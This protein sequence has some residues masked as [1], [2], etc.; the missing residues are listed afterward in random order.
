MVNYLLILCRSMEHYPLSGKLYRGA[1]SDVWNGQ[2]LQQAGK[3]FSY[4]ELSMNVPLFKSSSTSFW[5]VYLV[6]HNLPPDIRMNS[7]NT[8]IWGANQKSRV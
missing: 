2:V 4:P 3:L 1:V 5:P 7:E 6:V 8:A